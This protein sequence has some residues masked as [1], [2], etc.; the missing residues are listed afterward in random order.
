VRPRPL[1]L[2]PARGWA[3]VLGGFTLIGL[4]GELRGRTADVSLWW[5]DLRD[6]P[7]LVRT[8]LLG[9]FAVVLVVWAIR[10]DAAL[11]RRRLTA[12]LCG[13]LF[14]FAMR[15]VVRFYV[16]SAGG[17]VHAVVPIPFSLLVAL[18][19]GGLTIAVLRSSSGG[20]ARRVRG[21]L[22]VGV[23]VVGWGIMFPLAQMWFFGT[24]DYRRPA[25]VA[26]VF[27]ARVYASGSPSPLLEDRIQTGLELYRSGLVSTIVM[28]GG[29]GAD[30][31]NEAR[32]MRD[33]AIRAGVAP[34]A[35]VLDAA[36]DSTEATVA[37]TVALLTIRNGG[38]LPA[39]IIAVSQ[40][41]HLPRIQLSFATAGVDVLTVP[42]ADPVPIGEMPILVVREVPAFWVYFLRV[43]L[44]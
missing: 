13:V 15:D 8:V 23:S 34:S 25:D 10:P 16:A 12:V 21:L 35:I 19:L 14:A 5:V 18:S 22:A 32:V 28:S 40:A 31:F 41:Y 26:V 38:E 43:C 30:G 1:L 17:L 36:G 33:E 4:L 39:R 20:D 3:L 2:Y 24:T 27:G 7:D 44:G 42:A 6:L 29:D 9:A 37:N 11:P